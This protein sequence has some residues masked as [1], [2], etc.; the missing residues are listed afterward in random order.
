VLAAKVCA[1]FPKLKALKADRETSR[2]ALDRAT[3][4]N[5]PE[6]TISDVKV[7]AFSQ[8]MRERLT[9][10]AT[11]VRQGCL[12]PIIDRVDAELIKMTGAKESL[13]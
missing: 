8:L 2:A 6:I 5:R 3:G 12:G 11:S 7:R 9:G 13:G 1:V 4:T 10:G